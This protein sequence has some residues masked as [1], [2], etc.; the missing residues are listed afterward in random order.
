VY[1][2]E[3]NLQDHLENT[4]VVFSGHSNGQPEVMQVTDYYP[5]GMV[6][7]QENYF[8]SGVLANKYLYNNKELQDDELAG[9]SL[10]WYDYQTRFMDPELAMFHSID[11]HAENYYSWTPYN[12]VANNP[13]LLVDPNGMDWYSYIDDDGNEHYKYQEGNDKSIKVGDNT[14]SNIGS[15]VSINLNDDV[16]LNAFQNLTMQ[17]YGEAVDLKSKILNDRGLFLD[18][19][20]D[21]SDLSMQG[22]IELF[23]SHVSKSMGEDGSKVMM[24]I[25]TVTGGVIGAGELAALAPMLGDAAMNQLA[26][27]EYN[28]MFVSSNLSLLQNSSIAAGTLLNHTQ[29][30]QWIMAGILAQAPVGLQSG[31]N[32]NQRKKVIAEWLKKSFE[33][34]EANKKNK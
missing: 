4:R 18:Y 19:I 30:G 22:R 28:S 34:R 20:K 16:Y 27:M 8:A 24:G 33:L 6:M 15:T 23:G 9:N 17:S 7:N 2:F 21:G 26:M 29:T 3:N 11:A 25:A 14:Y 10:G 12:Y 13:V 5:F 1:K 31:F 32:V